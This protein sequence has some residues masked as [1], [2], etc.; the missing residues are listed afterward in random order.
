MVRFRTVEGKSKALEDDVIL[1]AVVKNW[2]P[3]LN[4]SSEN[5]KSVPN[6][7]CFRGLPL[8]YL[9]QFVLKKVVGIIVN[10]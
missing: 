8:K 3:D 6:W 4:L 10:L 1:Y 7:I 2:T 5:V 9:G